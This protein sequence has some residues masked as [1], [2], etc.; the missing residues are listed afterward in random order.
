MIFPPQNAQ[1]IARLECLRFGNPCYKEAESR[2]E[3]SPFSSGKIW[4]VS[5]RTAQGPLVRCARLGVV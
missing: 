2:G 3:G 4:E 5:H 1:E